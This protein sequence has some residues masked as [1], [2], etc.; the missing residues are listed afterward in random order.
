M[1]EPHGRA[2]G[3]ASAY[4]LSPEER[5]ERARMAGRVRWPAITLTAEEAYK[6]GYEWAFLGG[7]WYDF[8]AHAQPEQHRRHYLP[9]F[10]RGFAAG[11]DALTAASPPVEAEA[12]TKR[13]ARVRGRF[14]P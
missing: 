7:T 10:R 6:D 14:R 3:L 1:S 4:I 11:Y 5:R 12:R 9:H 8:E 2:G 13:A